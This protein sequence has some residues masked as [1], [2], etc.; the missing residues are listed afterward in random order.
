MFLTTEVLLIERALF[1]IENFKGGRIVL[2]FGSGK[3][4][5]ERGSFLLFVLWPVFTVFR[6]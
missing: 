1:C 4:Y 5:R 6:S 3:S 2:K